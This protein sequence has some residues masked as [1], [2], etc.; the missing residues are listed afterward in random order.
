[1]LG[2]TDF[3]IECKTG[4]NTLLHCLK[5]ELMLE[6]E[7]DARTDRPYIPSPLALCVNKRAVMRHH[8]NEINNSG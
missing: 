1:M 5:R 3:R 7:D 2:L 8:N 6:K 4:D